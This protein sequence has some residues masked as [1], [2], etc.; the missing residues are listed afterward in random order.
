MTDDVRLCITLSTPSGKV[1]EV[2]V[3]CTEYGEEKHTVAIPEP[4]RFRIDEFADD[5]RAS[6]LEAHR[7]KKHI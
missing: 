7:Q 1:L 6:V 5:A 2:F 3:L 4:D